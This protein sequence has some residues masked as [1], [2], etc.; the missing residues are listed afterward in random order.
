MNDGWV[1][2]TAP[3]DMGDSLVACGAIGLI[4]GTALHNPFIGVVCGLI[5][6]ALADSLLVL[7]KERIRD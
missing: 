5:L 4:A 2:P 7:R 3:E 6:G 1:R